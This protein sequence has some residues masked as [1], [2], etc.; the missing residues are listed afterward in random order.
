M[1]LIIGL[2]NVGRKYNG[3]RHNV[4][5]DTIDYLAYKNKVKLDKAKFNAVFG[6]YRINGEKVLLVKPTTYMNRSGFAVVDLKNFYKVPKEN[7]IVIYDDVD[8]ELGKLRIRPRGSAG[9][10]NGMKSVIYQLGD[11]NFPR[12]R[13]GVGKDERMDLAAYVLQKFPDDERELVKEIIEKA[14]DSAEEIVKKDV[15]KAMN[16]FN[17]R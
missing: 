15:D 2:G 6:E 8:L 14:G 4:G 1:H 7:I 16:R 13:I 5:F 12:I 9:S 17:I 10:H 11:D 3:T